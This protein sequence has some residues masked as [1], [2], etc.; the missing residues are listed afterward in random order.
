MAYEIVVKEFK[1]KDKGIWIYNREVAF[2]YK[3][4]SI[5]ENS[6]KTGLAIGV[7]QGTFMSA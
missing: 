1:S 7:R 2:E 4:T 3:K 5:N 6:A